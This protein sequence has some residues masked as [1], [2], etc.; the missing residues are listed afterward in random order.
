MSAYRMACAVDEDV[1]QL[2]TSCTTSDGTSSG[3]IPKSLKTNTKD[4][5]TG[6]DTKDTP[7]SDIDKKPVEVETTPPTDATG[8][9]DK[10]SDTAAKQVTQNPENKPQKTVKNAGSKKSEAKQGKKGTPSTATS[11]AKGSPSTVSSSTS[12]GTLQ[13]SMGDT[14]KCY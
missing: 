14:V 8:T 6:T 2:A 1:G 11:P 12:K 13:V 5:R 3:T 9:A 7:K 4:S 10:A